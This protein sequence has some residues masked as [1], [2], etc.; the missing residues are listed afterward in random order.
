MEE[1]S[2]DILV[3]GSGLA[4]LLAA[5]KAVGGHFKIWS[6]FPITLDTIEF[7]SISQLLAYPRIHPF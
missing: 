5:L 6:D 2:T 7:A 3:I 4:G 1:L